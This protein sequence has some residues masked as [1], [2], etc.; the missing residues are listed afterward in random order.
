MCYGYQRLSVDLGGGRGNGS[1]RARTPLLGL[2]PWPT[3]E[4]DDFGWEDAEEVLP[5]DK[6]TL[7]PMPLGSFL[8]LFG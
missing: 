5:P 3:S 1:P 4:G 6:T 7:L 2:S 8:P